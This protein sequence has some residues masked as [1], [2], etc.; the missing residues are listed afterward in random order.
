MR[1]MLFGVNCKAS[2]ARSYAAGCWIETKT[3]CEDVLKLMS[4][5]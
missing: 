2:R 1:N 4:H 5:F 3:V